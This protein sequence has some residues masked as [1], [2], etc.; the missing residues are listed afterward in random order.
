[1][2]DVLLVG[3]VHGPGEQFDHL[4]GLARILR[5]PLQ[6]PVQTAAVDEL[7]DEVRCA[8]VHAEVE[9]L[10]DVGMLQA[11]QHLRLAAKTDQRLGRRIGADVEHLQRHDAA[12]LGVDR[13]VDDTHAAGAEDAENLVTTNLFNSFRSRVMERRRRRRRRRRIGGARSCRM[14]CRQL[15]AILLRLGQQ[16][17]GHG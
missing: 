8:L 15:R 1:V 12:E 14:V 7:Q 13:P 3:D 2:D 6:L 4:R 11:A 17:G 10:D 5:L 16:S 9:H